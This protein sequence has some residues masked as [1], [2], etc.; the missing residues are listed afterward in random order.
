MGPNVNTSHDKQPQRTMSD[1]LA[2]EFTA[3]I[4]KRPNPP[5]EA[6]TVRLDERLH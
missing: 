2:H 6:V 4:Q 5:G 1:A 3:V